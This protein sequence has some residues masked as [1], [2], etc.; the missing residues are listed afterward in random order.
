VD[1]QPLS[2]DVRPNVRVERDSD[3][4]VIS[5]PVEFYAAIRNRPDIKEI[6]S[7]LARS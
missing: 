4:D 2:E 5:S 3:G 1:Q 6:L 7:R